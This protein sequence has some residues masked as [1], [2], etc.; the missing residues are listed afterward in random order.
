MQYQ[1]LYKDSKSEIPHQKLIQL[2]EVW[3]YLT[4]RYTDPPPHTAEQLYKMYLEQRVMREK[5]DT[6]RLPAETDGKAHSNV[7]EDPWP[8]PGCCQPANR[9]AKS[10]LEK[11]FLFSGSLDE[12]H[13]TRE[14]DKHDR[15][16]ILSVSN[17]ILRLLLHYCHFRFFLPAFPG[18]NSMRAENSDDQGHQDVIFIF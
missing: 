13:C 16:T 15:C 18:S 5:K 8:S 12:L 7:C 9:N 10:S 6:G 14:L 3:S 11:R 17:G 4:T 2:C 1:N